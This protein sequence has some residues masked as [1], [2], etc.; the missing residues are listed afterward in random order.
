M[1][2][3]LLTNL[4]NVTTELFNEAL[5][6]MD[7]RGPDEYDT[8]QYGSYWLGHNRL[9]VL[10]IHTRSKQPF[11]ASD[12]KTI[13]IFN[14]EIYNYLELKKQFNIETKTTSDTEILVELYL[15]LGK[16]ML[17][18]LN[19][20][21][22][23]VIFNIETKDTFICRDRLGIKPLYH[24]VKDD[25]FIFSSE[26]API[27][28]LVPGQQIDKIAIRQYLKART[29]FRNH[30]IYEDIKSFPAGHYFENNKF[31]KY[32]S[33]E[34]TDECEFS[35]EKIKDLI[36][37]AIGL[38]KVSDVPTGSYLSGGIDS[39]IITILAK[40]THSWT[41]G[42]P[43]CNEFEY[44]R[45]VA[46]PHKLNHH[47]ISIDYDEFKDIAKSLIDIRKEPLSVPNEVMIYKM[48]KA[49]KQH[50]TVILSGE[51]ADELFFGY[52]RIF[53]WAYNNE[54]N[55]SEFDKLYSY[56]SHRD[57]EILEY[58]LEPVQ[59]IQNNLQKITTFFQLHH[60]H[61][62]LRRLDSNT[63]L[64]SVEARVPFVDHRLV[65]YMYNIPFSYKM[66]NNVVKYPLKSIFSDVLPQ[67]V[68]NRKKIGFPAPINSIF[69]SDNGMD[70]WL[71]FN[72]QT[73]FKQ[74]WIEIKHDIYT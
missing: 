29:F 18:L 27:L 25:Q 15:K 70:N 74:N 20:M 44:A 30:T 55:L 57:D 3:I 42:F 34:I 66:K 45:L 4:T 28:K 14:G 11:L 16:K 26:L 40:Q 64:C 23:F 38:R 67:S 12:N 5:T 62:L 49:A 71:N 35:E 37:S 24:Y 1:C 72:L 53:K 36:T 6:S 31:Y 61:G 63:M 19:G 65:E 73:L 48:T 60:L 59:H 54:F 17:P 56:G 10:D 22:S 33:L 2:G 39:S 21:F 47:E 58:I 8:K 41:I 7:Y 32:W 68:I 69:N 51:G 9:R 13:I 43:D 50:N 46:K 52:D